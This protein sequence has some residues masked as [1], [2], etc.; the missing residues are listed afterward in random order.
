MK[1]EAKKDTKTAKQTHTRCQTLY[2]LLKFIHLFYKN[3]KY[4]DKHR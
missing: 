4:T 1:I 3:K 2:T